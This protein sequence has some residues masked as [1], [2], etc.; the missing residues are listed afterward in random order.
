MH[1][2][3]AN[4]QQKEKQ[5]DMTKEHYSDPKHMGKQRDVMKGKMKEHYS[6]QKI[7]KTERCDEIY[8]ERTLC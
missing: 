7:W 2:Y 1:K 4:E 6:D 3:Y 5:R 8:D